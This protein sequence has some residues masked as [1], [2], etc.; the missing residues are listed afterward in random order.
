MWYP[1]KEYIYI[2]IY[3]EVHVQIVNI[4]DGGSIYMYIRERSIQPLLVLSLL[5]ANEL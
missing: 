4:I 2:Y 3:S 5:R 1:K